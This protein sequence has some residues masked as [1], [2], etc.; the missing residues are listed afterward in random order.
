MVAGTIE[1]ALPEVFLSTS[2]ISHSNMAVARPP[3]PYAAPA[4][5]NIPFCKTQGVINKIPEVASHGFEGSYNGLVSASYEMALKFINTEDAEN[6][7][8]IDIPECTLIN[9][10][11]PATME[12]ISGLL[13]CAE[14]ASDGLVDEASSYFNEEVLYDFHKATVFKDEPVIVDFIVRAISQ[15]IYHAVERLYFYDIKHGLVDSQKYNFERLIDVSKFMYW[16]LYERMGDAASLLG[17]FIYL[18][19]FE[20]EKRSGFEIYFD[21][22]GYSEQDIELFFKRVNQGNDEVIKKLLEIRLETENELTGQIL[23]NIEDSEVDGV[24]VARID[25]SGRKHLVGAFCYVGSRV[26][27]FNAFQEKRGLSSSSES[28][29][30]VLRARA[31]MT[32]ADSVVDIDIDKDSFPGRDV[33]GARFIA[34][35]SL[36]LDTALK[37]LKEGLPNGISEM[38]QS[39]GLKVIAPTT[40]VEFPEREKDEEMNVRRRFTGVNLLCVLEADDV[41]N[42][43]LKRG[44]IVQ[45]QVLTNRTYQEISES[46]ILRK[47]YSSV[48]PRIS[49]SVGGS[50]GKILLTLEQSQAFLKWPELYQ[51]LSELY[52]DPHFV[53]PYGFNEELLAIE[54]HMKESVFRSQIDYFSLFIKHFKKGWT[55]KELESID[56]VRV[57]IPEE[58]QEVYKVHHMAAL[59]SS[60]NTYTEDTKKVIRLLFQQSDK[61]L[62]NRVIYFLLVDRFELKNKISFDGFFA[63][64]NK[65]QAEVRR[66]FN[67]Y[68]REQDFISFFI[69][70]CLKVNSRELDSGF[71]TVAKTISTLSYTQ[72][73]VGSGG[74]KRKVQPKRGRNRQMG[75]GGRQ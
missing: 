51:G 73:R 32:G 28:S 68:Y 27:G 37:N 8:E 30:S 12:L 67:N 13:F 41:I 65:V 58:D 4:R 24:N 26:K 33:L 60:I 72:R 39:I 19:N 2:E 18:A 23:S 16:I 10:D 75:K 71:E 56:G 62:Q 9:H 45:V 35:D 70:L 63:N 14:F 61:N 57:S 74:G 29:N 43:I 54:E 66:V 22:L 55:I 7:F 31:S 42:S 17:D 52:Y 20:A 3:S 21:A 5:E 38:L 1:A 11:K 6:P 50:R 69:N 40:I 15:G 46:A 59:L 49:F 44:S 36:D 25:N 34:E 53:V 64:S 47:R 48:M